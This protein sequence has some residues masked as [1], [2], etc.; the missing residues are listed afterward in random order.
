MNL[1]RLKDFKE[2]LN[3]LDE[4][5]NGRPSGY[6]QFI[7]SNNHRCTKRAFEYFEGKDLCKDCLNETLKSIHGIGR[8]IW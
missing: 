1:K 8:R 2:Y 4:L 7:K 6:C 5:D 3:E